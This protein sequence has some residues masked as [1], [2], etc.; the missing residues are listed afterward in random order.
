MDFFFVDDLP[1]YD[2][3]TLVPKKMT[4]SDIPPILKTAREI[5][6]DIDFSHDTLDA[7]LREGATSLGVKA[8]QM[9]QPI[10]VAVCGKMVAPPLF[11]TLEIL[12]KERVL[13]RLDAALEMLAI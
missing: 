4:L 2:P 13:A 12:G 11:D 1:P 9:F 6:A 8:G 5:L 10:R 3:Q 7:A